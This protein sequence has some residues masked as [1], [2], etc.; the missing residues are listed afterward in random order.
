MRWHWYRGRRWGFAWS[1]ERHRYIAGGRL[2]RWEGHVGPFHL[3]AQWNE[4]TW[5]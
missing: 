5:F 2:C 1:I 4:G 3:I